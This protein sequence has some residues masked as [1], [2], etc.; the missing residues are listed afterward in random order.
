MSEFQKGYD[1]GKKVKEDE[2]KRICQEWNKLEKQV[3]P[4]QG[5]KDSQKT[6]EEKRLESDYEIFWE[7]KAL[8]TTKE[9]EVSN[10]L[11]EGF[12]KAI[13]EKCK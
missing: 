11:A 3:V 1:L 8:K 2:C 4:L 13:L 12:K 5:K 9:K 6:Q 7:H 10:K